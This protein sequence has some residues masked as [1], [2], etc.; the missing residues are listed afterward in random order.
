[1]T[2]LPPPLAVIRDRAREAALFLD[3]DGTLAPIV[4]DP[5]AARPLPGVAELLP[6]L[7]ARLAL[8]AVVSGRPV[9]YLRSVLGRPPGVHLEGLYGMEEAIGDGPVVRDLQAQAW[10]GAVTEAGR[11]LRGLAPEGTEVEEKGLTVTLHWRRVP[12][13]GEEA[14][15]AA[16][17][18]AVRWGLH[19]QPGRMSMELRPPVSSDKGTVVLRLGAGQRVVGFFGDDLGDLP[20]FAALGTLAAHGASVVRVAVADDESPPAVLAGADVVLRGPREALDALR[21]IA[22][23]RESQTTDD[24]R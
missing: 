7:A 20:A 11:A 2:T 22:G 15:D 4:T 1:M 12:S 5:A 13:L 16:R 21:G 8:L 24:R 14:A 17:A 3:Y 18:A 6:R 19:A 9:G 10:S 23:C